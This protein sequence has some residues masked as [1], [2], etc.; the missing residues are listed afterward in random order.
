MKIKILLAIFVS[1]LGLIFTP[2]QFVEKV[3]AATC[4]WVGGTGSNWSVAA[5]WDGGCS[6]IGGIP[7]DGDSVILNSGA[8][9]FSNNNIA[10]LELADIFVPEPH[11]VIGIDISITNSIV[12]SQYSSFQMPVIIT[13]ANVTLTDCNFENVID[14]NSNTINLDAST[15]A[16]WEFYGYIDFSG[17][18]NIIQ[19]SWISLLGAANSGNIDL[20][21]QGGAK[22]SIEGSGW[23]NTTV[24]LLDFAYFYGDGAGVAAVNADGNISNVISASEQS[25]IQPIPDIMHIAGD[26]TLTDD[27]DQIRTV[28][29][30]TGVNNYDQIEVGGN[31]TLSNA[32]F[33]LFSND[34]YTATIGDTFTILSSAN[35]IGTFKDLP[36]GEII[37]LSKAGRYRINY[38]ATEITLTVVSGYCTWTGSASNLWSNGA[39]WSTGCSGTG[40]VPDQ[41]D[42][43]TFSG[44]SNQSTVNDLGGYLYVYGMDFLTPGFSITD[45]E[46][47][48]ADDLLAT[49]QATINSNIYMATPNMGG[50]NYGGELEVDDQIGIISFFVTRDMEITG[51]FD[52]CYP[53]MHIIFDGPHRLSLNGSGGSYCMGIGTQGGGETFVNGDYSNNDMIVYGGATLKGSGSVRT[54]EIVD[55]TLNPVDES[56]NPTIFNV[57]ADLNFITGSSLILNARG[58]SPGAT[59]HSQII[60]GHDVNNPEN[61]SLTYNITSFS[62]LIGDNIVFIQAANL[63]NGTQFPGSES[64]TIRDF[65]ENMEAYYTSNE[66]GYNG[67]AAAVTPDPTLSPTGINLTTLIAF[68]LLITLFGI[69]I[70]KRYEK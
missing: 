1:S 5:N 23:D 3:N 35:I 51:D 66:F 46:L 57:T 68:T 30:G 59:G 45:G 10:G 20:N 18:I 7:D 63:I 55:G 39:N 50:H 70:N 40:G 52:G 54:L 11:T 61:A 19:D 27:S 38:T 36:D 34:T 24:N 58:L 22:A 41:G 17:T 2:R 60:V 53:S 33:Y 15:N 31:V 48:I 9:G 47:I 8:A 64:G 42:R 13:S 29:A 6:G 43:I 56:G 62:P 12:C 65:G 16:H 26:L 44:T 28:I 69:Y 14:L 21:I 4:T 37:N 49:E 25:V 32:T 67:I